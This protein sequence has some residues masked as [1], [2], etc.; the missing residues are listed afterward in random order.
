MK[1]LQRL[2]PILTIWLSATLA[3][4][5]SVSC[6]DFTLLGYGPDAF[7]PGNSLIHILMAG[8]STGFINYPYI[9]L[10]T[11][12][13][14]DTIATGNMNFFGQTGQSVQSYPVTGDMT[15]ACLP[16]TVQLVYGNTNL[17]PD[18]CFISLN[19]LPTAVSC[20]AFTPI[21]IE[22][23]QSNTLVNISMLGTAN[24]YISN[25]RISFVTDC[26]GDTI[27][28]GFV[29]SSGQLGQ[30]AQGY[31]ITAPGSAVC[32]P[33]IVA[34]I[35]G[36]TNFETDTCLLTLASP[37]AV[38]ESS[39]TARGISVFVNPASSE[40]TIRAGRW[41][42]EDNYVVYDYQGKAVLR[43]KLT[44]ENT[45]LDM[46]SFSD[47]IYFIYIEAPFGGVYKVIKQ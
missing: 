14:G 43:G 42:Y 31:P 15:N 1:K 28:T 22:V 23:D 20:S 17:A 13:N 41:M 7:D 47:G 6:A 45:L 27:A 29:N 8:D 3:N 46:R 21:D 11:D 32:Y 18:T 39:A 34:F 35:Y 5:Q 33:V 19:S 40:I 36:N 26:A 12:C 38:P 10:V 30:S 16:I 9:A 2:I 44:A 37:T 25:P 24:T 4:A